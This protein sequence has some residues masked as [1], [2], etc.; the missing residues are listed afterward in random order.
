MEAFS[1]KLTDNTELVKKA[2]AEQIRKALER[3]GLHG[4]ARAKKLCP[5]DTGNLRNSIT[6]IVHDK[7]VDIGTNSEY[8][9]YVEFGTGIYSTQG[10]RQTPWVYYN[11]STGEFVTTQGNHPQ[12]FLKP[13]I[14]GGVSDFERIIKATLKG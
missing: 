7:Q 11:K 4:E 14:E 2:T 1:M 8:G 5:V 3:C 10:G 13:A 12:P 6:H 9:T